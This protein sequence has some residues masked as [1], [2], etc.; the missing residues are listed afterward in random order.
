[1]KLSLHTKI[2]YFVLALSL[3]KNYATSLVYAF[4]LLTQIMIFLLSKN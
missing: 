1:M 2:D 3:L 4:I